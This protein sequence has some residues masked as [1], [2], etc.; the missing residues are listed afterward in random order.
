LNANKN[1]QVTKDTAP[2]QDSLLT[3]EDVPLAIMLSYMNPVYCTDLLPLLTSKPL[4]S[5]VERLV[6]WKELQFNRVDPL[7]TLR[8]FKLACPGDT[9]RLSVTN[10]LKHYTARQRRMATEIFSR[11]PHLRARKELR[12][13]RLDDVELICKAGVPSQLQRLFFDG[14]HWN[15][16][17]SW[18]RIVQLNFPASLTSMTLEFGDSN[19]REVWGFFEQFPQVR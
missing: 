2:S 7:S 18:K 16:N 14:W 15:T 3:L 17:A 5:R 6:P 19:G 13:L 1:Q 9:G 11:F 10:L 4:S 8:V 12:D